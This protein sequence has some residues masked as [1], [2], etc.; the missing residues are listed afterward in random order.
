V[1]VASPQSLARLIR[2][3]VPASVEEDRVVD[4]WMQ[5]QN[6]R[7]EMNAESNDLMLAQRLVCPHRPSPVALAASPCRLTRIRI[8]EAEDHYSDLYVALTLDGNPTFKP[9]T[10]A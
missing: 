2:G 10:W 6:E 5:P 9:L 1:I 8:R 4:V 3:A 7:A